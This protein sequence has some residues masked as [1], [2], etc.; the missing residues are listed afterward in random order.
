MELVVPTISILTV[1]GLFPFIGAVARAIWV[2]Y[3]ITSRRIA[4]TS[5]FQGKDQTEI[6][7]RDIDMIKYVRR[8][9]DSADVVITLK[10]GAKIEIRSLPQFDEAYKFIMDNVS[11]EVR[12]V[13]GA[14]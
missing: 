12:E 6:I 3:K 8:L 14:A 7:Y 1:I 4:V 13:S 2:R 11:E 10:D 5:G 9:G